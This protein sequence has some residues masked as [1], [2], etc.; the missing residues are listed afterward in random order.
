MTHTRINKVVNKLT[1]THTPLQT[2]TIRSYSI[3]IGIIIIEFQILELK[4][5]KNILL[6]L[7]DS[8]KWYLDGLGVPW[9]RQLIWDTA[10]E[11][12]L[13]DDLSLAAVEFFMR[14][15]VSYAYHTSE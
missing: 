7:I 8:V 4:G 5:V 9:M 11:R 10:M 1:I 15:L 14:W 6:F 3:I 2:I 13:S 12:R